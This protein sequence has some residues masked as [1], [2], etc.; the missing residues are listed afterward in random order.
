M[1]I[2]N[3][4][5]DNSPAII[6]NVFCSTK[7]Y[8]IYKRRYNHI[9]HHH[10]KKYEDREYDPKACLKIFL[11]NISETPFY[12]QTFSEYGFNINAEDVYTE[13]GKLP[14]INK[15]IVKNNINLFYNSGYKG[16]TLTMKT[17]G[18]TGSGLVF[19]YSI[20]MENREWA[21]VWR[22]RRLH[23]IDMGWWCGWFGGKSIISIKNHSFPYWRINIPGKQVMFSAYHLNQNTVKDYYNEIAKRHLKWLHGYPSN[24]SLLASCIYEKGLPPLN[25]V[26]HITLSSEN[27]LENQKNI[28]K[29]IFSRAKICQ[30]YGLSE[31]VASISEN[32]NGDLAVNDDFCHVE[33]IPLLPENPNL[34]RI[35]GT[36]FS[37]EAFPLIR[38][39]TGDI[40]NVEYS[41]NRATKILSIDGR[42]EDFISLPN[43][44]KLGRLDHIFKDLTA[45]T[46]AQIHQK[47]LYHIDFNIVKGKDYTVHDENKLLKEIKMRINDSVFIKINYVDEIEHTKTGK[48]RFV[49]SDLSS[50]PLI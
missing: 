27:L 10:L 20:E 46:A 26:T 23:G 14:V 17:S 21:V 25:C 16:K 38:Y 29:Q 45:V 24:L 19:P 41:P 5:Y 7:G 11:K 9:F 31:G 22:F 47:D 28:I 39:D 43:G 42:Q 8:L 12:K 13:L 36:G 4:I 40:A 35:I 32:I 50:P 15:N 49:I 18:S 6:Q 37:N 48:L 3:A 34:C 2:L 44:V 30:H 1:S 33:F